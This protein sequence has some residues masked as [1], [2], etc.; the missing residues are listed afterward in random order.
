MLEREGGC[1]CVVRCALCTGMCCVLC[2]END[3][4]VLERE[5]GCGCVVRCLHACVVCSV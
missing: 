5:G 2:A 3:F 1:A 4:D